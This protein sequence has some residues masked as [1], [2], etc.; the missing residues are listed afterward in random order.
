M[1]SKRLKSNKMEEVNNEISHDEYSEKLNKLYAEFKEASAPLNDFL[2]RNSHAIMS[3]G[4]ACFN[5]KWKVMNVT[6][7]GERLR[8]KS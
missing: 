2:D 1:K 7:I 3:V 8:T 5:T 6:W 4:V